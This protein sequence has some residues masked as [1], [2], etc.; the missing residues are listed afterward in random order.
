MDPCWCLALL[1]LTDPS[2]NLIALEKAT[3]TRE[4]QIESV[5]NK[6]G[7]QMRMRVNGKE[8]HKGMTFLE[9]MQLINHHPSRI[10]I[11]RGKGLAEYLTRE[12]AFVIYYS[13]NRIE[14]MAFFGPY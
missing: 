10:E 7:I 13:K 14:Y 1:F 6:A 5:E 12:G 3:D 8:I 4:I 2:V 11:T 9:S